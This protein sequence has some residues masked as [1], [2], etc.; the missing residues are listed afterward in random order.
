MDQNKGNRWFCHCAWR[1]LKARA[2]FTRI[3]ALAHKIWTCGGSAE[4]SSCH[5]WGGLPPRAHFT[6]VHVLTHKICTTVLKSLH[7]LCGPS[8]VFLS[9]PS[10]RQRQ[11]ESVQDMESKSDCALNHCIFTRH[12]LNIRLPRWLQKVQNQ[13]KKRVWHAFSRYWFQSST[14][15]TCSSLVLFWE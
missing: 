7:F 8:H 12:I 6:R 14:Q 15:P 1:R 3:Y 5:A 10:L 4:W 9:D 13:D 2:H 11:I